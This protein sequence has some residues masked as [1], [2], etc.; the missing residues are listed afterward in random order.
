MNKQL[1]IEIV[2]G[3]DRPESRFIGKD[4]NKREVYQQSAYMHNGEAFPQKLTLMFDSLSECLTVGKY[5]L[6]PKSFRANQYGSL[7]LDRYNMIFDEIK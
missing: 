2:A 3:H 6:N 1:V 5:S 4:E 7:E